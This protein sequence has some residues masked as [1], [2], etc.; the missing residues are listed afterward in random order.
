LRGE[1]NPNGTTLLEGT[2]LSGNDPEHNFRRGPPGRT[3]IYHVPTK[4]TAKEGTGTRIGDAR[5]CQL[6]FAKIEAPDAG[7]TTVALPKAPAPS[8]LSQP[9]SLS[10]SST[11]QAGGL[12]TQRDMERVRAIASRDQLLVM[13]EF[14]IEHP[15][16][17]VPATLRRFIGIWAS[18]VAFGN[19]QDRHAML[20]VTKVEASGDVTGYWIWGPATAHAVF[21]DPAGADRVYGK[22]TGNR[23]TFPLQGRQPNS[24]TATL[25]RGG[26]LSIVHVRENVIGHI[27]L[28][29]VWQLLN[30][31][32]SVATLPKNPA[33]APTSLEPRAASSKTRRPIGPH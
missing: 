20:I 29:P 25:N 7:I 1:I 18:N 21:R 12:F 10:P 4:F 6:T 23:L 9:Q 30:A 5:H 32:R 15:G 24:V 26:D 13:P 27:T 28:E 3:F 22:I 14:I 31:E 11:E 2:G 19:G 17:E 8:E 16:P 33:Q